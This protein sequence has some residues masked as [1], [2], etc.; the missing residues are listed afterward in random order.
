MGKHN[1]QAGGALGSANVRRN[2]LSR[3]GECQRTSVQHLRR[4][5]IFFLLAVEIEIPREIQKNGYFCA[6]FAHGSELADELF[7]H[8]SAPLPLQGART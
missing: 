1:R 6:L 4:R 2:Q 3:N 8:L 5:N 7:R